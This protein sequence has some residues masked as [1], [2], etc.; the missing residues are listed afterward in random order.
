MPVL[1]QFVYERHA[2]FVIFMHLGSSFSV[3][4]K[5]GTHEYALFIIVASCRSIT[6]VDE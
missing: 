2:F 4:I 3:Y 1:R 5:K 6:V